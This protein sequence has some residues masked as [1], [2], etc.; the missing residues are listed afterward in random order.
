MAAQV[1]AEKKLIQNG[2]AGTGNLVSN[3]VRASEGTPATNSDPKDGPNKLK[4]LTNAE[5]L[6]NIFVFNF[7]GH[8]TTAISLAYALLLLVAH[9]EVQEWVHEEIVHYVGSQDPK[10]LAYNDLFPKLKRSLA[11]LVRSRF[12]SLLCEIQIKAS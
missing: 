4:P 7:A 6:G 11:V 5:I 8:D 10:T 12:T 3:L 2:E 9:P 1:A